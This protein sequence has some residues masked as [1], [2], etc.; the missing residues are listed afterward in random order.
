M[1]IRNIREAN[2]FKPKMLVIALV[3]DKLTW[4]EYR[5]IRDTVN[6]AN[7]SS[8]Y[9]AE[10]AEKL[11]ETLPKNFTFEEDAMYEKFNIKNS[12]GELVQVQMSH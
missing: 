2:A 4:G 10:R 9:F 11:K 12:D 5:V 7:D 1:G 3:T 8:L 6:R